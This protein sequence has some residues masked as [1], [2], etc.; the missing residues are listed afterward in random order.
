MPDWYERQFFDENYKTEGG[1]SQ[2]EVRQRMSEAFEE[3]VK[4]N[5]GKRIAIFSHG[6]AITFFL[7]KWR[8]FTKVKDH[9]KRQPPIDESFMIAQIAVVVE[10]ALELRRPRRLAVEVHDRRVRLAS[11]L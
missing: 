5:K 10:Q 8:Q 4:D 9:P 6:N 3:V 2:A 11:I 1:E 7:L